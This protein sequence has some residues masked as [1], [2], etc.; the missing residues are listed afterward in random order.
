MLEN[1]ATG[2][3]ITSVR[4]KEPIMTNSR[5]SKS[6]ESGVIEVLLA[7]QVL[8]VSKESCLNSQQKRVPSR[9][10]S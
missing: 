7:Q 6:E 4:G 10:L 2:T 1:Q 8:E 3:G 9:S 5:C